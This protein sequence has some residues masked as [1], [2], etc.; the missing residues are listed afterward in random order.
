[1]VAL[2]YTRLTDY[3]HCPL[4]FKLR[5][6]ERVPVPA[7]RPL[8]VGALA[9]TIA[10]AYLQQCLQEGRAT[11]WGALQQIT[12]AHL[13]TQP[14]DLGAEVQEAL[15][16]L[17]QWLVERSDDYGVEEE[18]AFTRTWE[19]CDWH[20]RAR[21]FFRAKIDYHFRDAGGVRVIV[22][23]KTDRR[24]WSREET[25]QHDQLPIYAFLVGRVR[26]E[27]LFVVRVHFLRYGITRTRAQPY[28]RSALESIRERIEAQAQVIDADTRFEPRLS[29][30]CGQCPYTARCPAFQSALKLGSTPTVTSPTE[31]QDEALRLLLLRKGVKEAESRLKAWVD[32]HGPIPLDDREALGYFPK[33]TTAFDRVEPVVTRL[34]QAG[35]P[36]P[37]VWAILSTSKSAIQQLLKDHHQSRLMTEILALARTDQ[38]TQFSVQRLAAEE[39]SDEN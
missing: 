19:P 11:D 12:R 15:E 39:G 35:L 37:E 36:R 1:M 7:A 18:L 32:G 29:P 28:E 33:R 14:A 24:L 13:L 30:F 5:H 17:P 31:A 8:E 6:L 26:P 21:V 27:E 10:A 9:H 3:Q 22:D 25:A 20:D 34:L 38:Q 4:A 16:G 2:S 23:H